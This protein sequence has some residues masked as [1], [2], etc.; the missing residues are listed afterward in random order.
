MSS[1]GIYIRLLF[2]TQSCPLEISVQ[3]KESNS[4]KVPWTIQIQGTCKQQL[5][6]MCIRLIDLGPYQYP[7]T[8][9]YASL[10]FGQ[11]LALSMELC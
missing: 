10:T 8:E 7:E 4:R 6:I 5:Y 2:K 1:Q 11:C 9:Q 3:F